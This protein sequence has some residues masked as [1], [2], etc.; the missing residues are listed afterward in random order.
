MALGWGGRHGTRKVGVELFCCSGQNLYILFT[1]WLSTSVQF[2]V[3]G[4]V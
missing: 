1:L 3:A 4:T 2:D